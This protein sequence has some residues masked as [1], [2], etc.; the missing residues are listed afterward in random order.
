ML[1]LSLPIL[2]FVFNFPIDWK[3]LYKDLSLF[4]SLIYNHILFRGPCLWASLR[5]SRKWVSCHWLQGGQ[6]QV[7]LA[8]LRLLNKLPKGLMPVISLLL[9]LV[10]FE[11]PFH[12]VNYCF[13][14]FTCFLIDSLSWCSCSC[15]ISMK[16]GDKGK[17]REIMRKRKWNQY[18]ITGFLFW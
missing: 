1:P 6:A 14:R 9:S 2:G 4:H 12:L 15:L 16:Y 5:Y 13:V 10:S 7:G 11:F 3:T 17:G 18:I 8:Q